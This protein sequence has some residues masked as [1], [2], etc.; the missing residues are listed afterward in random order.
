MKVDYDETLRAFKIY[1][2]EYDSA[3]V[4]LSR[5]P[6]FKSFQV[7]GE[8]RFEVVGRFGEVAVYN[9]DGRIVDTR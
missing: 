5:E 7:I 8:D 6:D 3:Y 4:S 1:K 9:S 2:S